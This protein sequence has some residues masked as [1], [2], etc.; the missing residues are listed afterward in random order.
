MYPKLTANRQNQLGC[1]KPPEV[2]LSHLQPKAGL[3]VELIRCVTQLDVLLKCAIESPTVINFPGLAIHL[4]IH[5]CVVSPNHLFV[6]VSSFQHELGHQF[7]SMTSRSYWH[8]NCHHCNAAASTENQGWVY[9]NTA[10]HTCGHC[11]KK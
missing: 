5:T 8:S 1:A 7:L 6:L 2:T 9:S 4:Y 3:T 10:D 11:W